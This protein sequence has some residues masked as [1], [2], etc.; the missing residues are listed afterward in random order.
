MRSEDLLRILLVVLN[1][2]TKKRLLQTSLAAGLLP[3]TN[4]APKLQTSTRDY[5]KAV[6][7]SGLERG[8]RNR[9]HV[10]FVL[11]NK[12]IDLV[13]S[14]PFAT[15]IINQE[16]YSSRELFGELIFPSRLLRVFAF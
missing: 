14:F 6:L 1:R 9:W 12:K 2:Q 10:R 8:T 5:R 15:V 3:K 7:L 11:V 13:V 16:S 4:L